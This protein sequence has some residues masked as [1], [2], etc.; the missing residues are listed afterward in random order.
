MISFWGMPHSFFNYA[1]G[2]HRYFDHCMAYAT[3]YLIENGF[4]DKNTPIPTP[5]PLRI[6]CVGNSITFGARLENRE[7]ECYPK[8]LNEIL[9]EDYDVRNFG[10]SARTLLSKGDF[11]YIN[12]KAYQDM[13]A[14]N[15]DFI[16][17]MLG[18]NDSKA[19]NWQ[20]KDEFVSDYQSLIDS[21]KKVK[22]PGLIKQMIHPCLPPVAFTDPDTPKINNGVIHDEVIPLIEEVA[23]MDKL[24]VIDLHTPFVGCEEL[25]P[26][27]VHPNSD[28]AK[29]LAEQIYNALK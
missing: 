3:E 5:E 26:D 14:F 6:A 23:K 16:F 19:H 8:R 12:E 17:I 18:T 10:V 11:P 1:E 15:P 29:K 24:K 28:G 9:G 4:V 7:A 22:A 20:Y 27:K 21:I 13:L 2:N 25:F